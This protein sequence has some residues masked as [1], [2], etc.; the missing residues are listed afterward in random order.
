MA[1]KTKEEAQNTRKKI[2]EAALDVF[3]AKGVGHS[4]LED[5]AEVAGVTRGA[6]Y[7]HFK[8]KA[9]IFNELHREI[10]LSFINRLKD[11][12]E[13][14]TQNPLQQLSTLCI[15][16]LQNIE[17]DFHKRKFFTVFFL[18]CDYAGDL[19]AL[20]PIQDAQRSESL[21]I[22]KGFFER[23]IQQGQIT[24]NFDARILAVSLFCFM[25]GII[26]ECLR[27]SEFIDLKNMTRPMIELYFKN[28]V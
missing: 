28:L 10:H 4:S 27:D 6:V 13:R 26:H 7:W 17:T 11:T 9:D 16:S 20:I 25:G 3:Y 12:Q 2:L 18:K 1:R 24:Q 23:A 5:I 15:N 14:D 19:A 21:N 8:N 22:I